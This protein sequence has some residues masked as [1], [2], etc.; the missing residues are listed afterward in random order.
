MILSQGFVREGQCQEK[1]NSLCFEQS[2]TKGLPCWLNISSSCFSSKKDVIYKH[3]SIKNKH[4]SVINTKK[5]ENKTEE[6][7]QKREKN[8]N[9]KPNKIKKKI[10]QI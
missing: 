4:A 9:N 5:T 8:T 7:N 2:Y 3:R 10:K 1:H 6:N